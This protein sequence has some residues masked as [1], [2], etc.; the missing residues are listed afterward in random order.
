MVARL[1]IAEGN[2]VAEGFGGIK[3][4]ISA[5][6]GLQQAVVAQVFVYKQGKLSAHQNPSRTCST[7]INRS[8]SFVLTCCG[9]IAVIVLKSVAVYAEIGL[10]NVVVGYGCAQK[11]LGAAVHG[12]YVKIFV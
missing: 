4:T 12:R 8:I 2:D 6:I 7:T 3:N 11:P 1:Q 5:R 10:F 9:Q